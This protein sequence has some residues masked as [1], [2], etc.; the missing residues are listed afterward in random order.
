MANIIKEMLQDVATRL[1]N[2]TMQEPFTAPLILRKMNDVYHEINE[3]AKALQSTYVFDS[4]NRETGEDYWTLP[5]DFIQVYGI[6]CGDDIQFIDPD[7]IDW[8]ETEYLYQYTIEDGKIKV[9]NAASDFEM[10]LHYYSAGLE[11]AN[12]DDADLTAGTNT[13]T[14]AWDARHR[15]TLVLGTCLRM[16]AEY[17]GSDRDEVE[18]QLGKS[19]LTGKKYSSSSTEP[20][21]SYNYEQT[22]W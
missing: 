4:T 2:P 20:R 10:T 5:S 13:N 3:D 18:F 1:G 22:Q 6:E 14:P 21:V 19:R 17:P 7:S 11:L 9:P 8:A 16:S 15:W 12:L